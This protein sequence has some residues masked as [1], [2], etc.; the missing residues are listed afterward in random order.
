MSKGF[1]NVPFQGNEEVLNYAPGS[2]EREELQAKYKEMY[3]SKIEVPSYIGSK[4]IHTDNKF[5]MSPPH[6]HKHSLGTYSLGTKKHVE[7]AIDAALAAKSDWENMAWN[8]RAAIFLKAADLLAGPY[9]AKMNAATFPP[10]IS[11]SLAAASAVPPVAI[12]SSIINTLSPISIES[13]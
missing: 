11:T 7:D 10:D 9:R 1:Y 4:E 3:N 6:D 5:T 2:A 8:S 13:L 12:R